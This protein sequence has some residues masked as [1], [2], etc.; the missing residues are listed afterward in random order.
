MST[1]TPH[2]HRLLQKFRFVFE[3][4]SHRRIIEKMLNILQH[5][6]RHFNLLHIFYPLMRK[7]INS[8]ENIDK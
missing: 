3:V 5:L 2:S 6:Y 4:I 1:Y 7:N 8:Q